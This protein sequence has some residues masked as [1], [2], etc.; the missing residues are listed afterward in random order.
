MPKNLKG[1]VQ[2]TGHHDAEHD[3]FVSRPDDRRNESIT[4]EEE[5]IRRRAYEL[6]VGRGG[7]PNGDLEGWL[8][9]EREF[10]E[11]PLSLSPESHLLSA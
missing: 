1:R 4:T 3:A 2:E 9:A 8:Q 11:R 5:E 10:R 6:Y 7:Q